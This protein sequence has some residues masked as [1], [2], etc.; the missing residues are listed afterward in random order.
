M[1]INVKSPSSSIIEAQANRV[2]RRAEKDGLI[3]DKQPNELPSVKK[4][5]PDTTKHIDNTISK[6]RALD[7]KTY[8]EVI[9]VFLRVLLDDLEFYN[10][11]STEGLSYSAI[12]LDISQIAQ[13]CAIPKPATK[14][15]VII[16]HAMSTVNET[17]GANLI[18]FND[19]HGLPAL[20]LGQEM[21]VEL[22]YAKLYIPID[23]VAPDLIILDQSSMH[24][25]VDNH[26]V[27]LKNSL[28]GLRHGTDNPAYVIGS[29]EVPGWK[30]FQNAARTAGWEIITESAREKQLEAVLD[31]AARNEGQI[32]T[33]VSSAVD[34]V[35]DLENRG[36]EVQII[37]EID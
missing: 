27:D 32:I 22:T 2:R 18:E 31:L 9:I 20:R 26:R 37:N 8:E 13:K 23:Y 28:F 3:R 7:S 11:L 17:T 34:I 14:F 35:A 30:A 5:V 36:H 12:G 24:G 21:P 15:Q 4:A 25:M 16:Q 29:D 6:V 1:G 19:A 10:L 33:I